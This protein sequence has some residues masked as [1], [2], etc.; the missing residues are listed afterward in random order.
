MNN[1]ILESNTLII[2]SDLAL[3]SNYNADMMGYPQQDPNGN[4]TVSSHSIKYMQKMYYLAMNCPIMSVESHSDEKNYK[5]RNLE[6]RYEYLFNVSAKKQTLQE[7]I[8]NAFTCQDVIQNG[9]VLAIKEQNVAIRGAAQTTEGFNIHPYTE[10]IEKAIISPYQNSKKADSKQTTMGKR[11]LLDVAR[12]AHSTCVYP[13]SYSEYVEQGLCDGYTEENLEM[14]KNATLFGP[15][16]TKSVAKSD[17]KNE[18]TIVVK[19]K[20]GKAV[21]PVHR[22]LKFIPNSEDTNDITGIYELDLSNHFL[23]EDIENIEVYY[24]AKTCDINLTLPE[25]I[26]AEYFNVRTKARIEHE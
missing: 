1:K 5:P 18:L 14:L 15:S 23:A 19:V 10:E 2:A 17:I 24:D 13:A 26:T 25:G 7:I 22:L 12:F 11:R 6:E 4:Y 3:E 21:D 9:S 20:Q 16:L 8:K